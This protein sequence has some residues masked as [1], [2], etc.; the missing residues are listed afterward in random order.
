VVILSLA[1]GCA[2]QAVLGPLAGKETGETALLRK[3]LKSLTPGDLVV[4]DRYYCNYW[5]IALMIACGVDVCFRN[6]QCR[7]SDFRRG[8]RLGKHDHCI[9]W[10]RPPR[11]A[12]LTPERYATMPL[13]L[14]L[15]EVRFTRSKPGRKQQPLVIITTLGKAKGEQVASVDELGEL[16]SFRWNAELDLRS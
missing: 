8:K 11:P 15:R 4:A 1:T 2:L 6:H 13:T 10:S 16:Y 5:I 7:R 3:L 12:W 9:T 14:E